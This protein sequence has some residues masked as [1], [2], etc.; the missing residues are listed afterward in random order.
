MTR[1]RRAARTFILALLLTIALTGLAGAVTRHPLATPAGS[2]KPFFDSRASARTTARTPSRVAGARAD[3]RARYG[4]QA[5]VAADDLTGTLRALTRLDG[6]LSGPA[7]GD[8]AA[9]GLAFARRNAAAIGLADADFDTLR[10]NFRNTTAN[11]IT[12][13][14][15][16]QEIGGI[17]FF[18]NDLRVNLDRAGRVL[19]VLG[20]P[21]HAPSVESTE[22]A[23]SATEALAALQ[24]NVGVKR[25]MKIRSQ[26]RGARR[27]AKFEGGD[28]ARLVLFAGAGGTRLAWHVTYRAT[29][30]A[31][32][33]AIVDAR[34]GAV[35]YRQNL[36]KFGDL[37]GF[38]V[39]P[40]HPD[41][42]GTPAL[43]TMPAQWLPGG[44]TALDGPN[45]HA[46]TDVD[47][48][49]TAD[50]AEEVGPTNGPQQRWRHLF[51]AFPAAG[52][53]DATHLCGW[54]SAVPTSWQANREHAATNA[55]YLVN[56]FHDHLLTAPIGFAAPENFETEDPVS[57]QALDGAGTD[58]GGGPDAD[59]LNNAN[60]GTPA[61]PDPPTMQMYLWDYETPTVDN[62]YAFRDIDGDDSA[63]IV[64]H[65]YTHGLSNRLVVN[66]DG[67][68]AVSTPHAGAMGEAWS[69]WYAEDFLAREGFVVDDPQVAG[70]V[71]L[72]DYTDAVY[73]AIRF[74]AMDCTIGSDADPAC[75]GGFTT[76]PGGFTFGDFGHVFASAEVHSDGEIW[77]ATL[78]DLR[79][80]L[81]A[82][83]GSETA[84]SD[85]AEQLVTDGMRLSPVEPSFLDMRNAILAADTAAGGTHHDLIWDVFQARGMGFFAGV[86]DGSDVA[87]AEDFSPPPP[88]NG[89]K[90]T[91]AGVV[92]SADTG[93]PVPGV[94]VGIGGLDS[95]PSIPGFLAGTSGATGAYAVTGVPV[96]TYPKLAFKPA[97]GFD[98]LIVADVPVAD[99]ATVTRDGAVRRDW[100]ASKGGAV[101]ATNH[102]E[103][104][105]FGC[106]V[107]Q[108]VDQ[109]TGAGW[110]SDNPTAGG[111]N[112]D[113]PTAV[114]ELPA[115]VD[116]TAFGLDPSNTCGDGPSASTKDW[117]LETSTDGVAY[118]LAASGTF[119]DE[120]RNK[121]NLITPTAGAADVKF[122]RLTLLSVL[123]DAPGFSGAQYIDFSELEV[124]GGPRN[125]LP[126][127]TLAVSRTTAGLNEAL[128]FDA[129]SFTDADSLITGYDWDFDGDGTTDR[130]TATPATSFAYDKAGDF[131]AKVAVKD[132]RGGAGTGT[133]A[134]KIT[135]AAVAPV[136][137]VVPTV[138]PA[139]PYTLPLAAPSI[140][141]SRTSKKARARYRVTCTTRCRV[142]GK[143]TISRR[144]ANRL[145]LKSRTIGTLTSTINAAGKR[146]FLLK[147][148]R[149][150]VKAAR[151]AKA[152]SIRGSLVV[153]AKDTQ[154]PPRTK[155]VRRTVTIRL[156]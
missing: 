55:F 129:A 28:F 130:T 64:Y 150:A 42:G 16:V 84:G 77:A 18:D 101:P 47:G 133:Q 75:P 88:A 37:R 22:P 147:I 118:T 71:Y 153:T 73:G 26:S 61:D 100:A 44:S 48:D 8:A 97:A 82:D 99:G 60:M 21:V 113:P 155:R 108:L 137:T 85:A 45:A 152:K 127:G 36:V 86:A 59:H 40:G 156:K 29:S 109:S 123:N 35:L 90:G 128:T 87:P 27:E 17:P 19:N 80:A 1:T 38:D 49:D 106:G 31:F 146:T 78:W 69:D 126:A 81:V 141:I 148:K 23:L 131:T 56:K 7:S 117:K 96:G 12:R 110:S 62:P 30:Q 122:V 103:Y 132:F 41:D 74:Q 93:L 34:S 154:T 105:G 116:V 104:A 3:L 102:D 140:S 52:G 70:D 33:D 92:T 119:A 66:A 151:R 89:A 10:L 65:E 107:A 143:L 136:P 79:Q 43:R 149:N 142:V 25:A 63:S 138:T 50:A 125:V 111:A 94:K 13:L 15:Y 72:G 67:T 4:P 24:E 95:S 83:L 139:K 112:Q 91:I 51:T 135:A 76:G 57:T 144:L 134:V 53:C 145:H 39:Y 6:A 58:A 121:L 120:N 124:F 98:P 115:K 114:I 9:V 14:R 2:A 54:N 5:V 46:F 11:G 68:G 20:A 32:Y